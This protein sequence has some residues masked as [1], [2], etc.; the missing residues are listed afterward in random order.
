MG[1]T[2]VSRKKLSLSVIF[3]GLPGRIREIRKRLGL[4]QEEFGKLLGVQ[5]PTISR[6]ESGRVPDEDML[7]KIA[8]AGNTTI[9]WLLR[10]DQVPPP[11]PEPDEAVTLESP[12]SPG[13]IHEP[14]VFVGI[15]VQALAR[16]IELV[17]ERL[18][19]RRK[20]LKSIKK[21][22]LISL[23]FDEFQKTGLLPDADLVNDFLRRI[24]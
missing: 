12:R 7:K 10:G 13:L 16:I 2:K 24:D 6:Y 11:L 23:L 18:A 1:T 17:D 9:D 4:N 19:Q 8:N 22:F 3:S 5:K 21:S 20:P 14:Y 15:D